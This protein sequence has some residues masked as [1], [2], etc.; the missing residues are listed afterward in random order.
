MEDNLNVELIA[1]YASINDEL[2]EQGENPV[3]G[4]IESEL[5][6]RLFSTQTNYMECVEAIKEM[7]AP[8]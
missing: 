4:N 2:I 1:Y 6:S 5:V 7:R 3:G 8:H